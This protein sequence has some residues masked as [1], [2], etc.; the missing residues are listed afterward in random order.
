MAVQGTA[1]GRWILRTLSVVLGVGV[2][3]ACN[4][5]LT[6]GQWNWWWTG[7]A[8]ALTA[9]SMAVAHWLTRVPAATPGTAQATSARQS[10]QV[11]DGSTAVGHI[12]QLRGITGNVHLHGSPTPPSRTVDSTPPGTPGRSP[13][14]AGTNAGEARG[15]A[16]PTLAEGGQRVSRSQAGGSIIQVDGVGGDVTIERP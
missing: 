14:P 11:V 9:G 7:I 12:A 8:V 13:R 10:G 6:D 3:V 4:Q 5:V 1:W 15:D 2:A 16:E